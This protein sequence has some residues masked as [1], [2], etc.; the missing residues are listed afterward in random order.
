MRKKGR[1]FLNSLK[2][3]VEAQNFGDVFSTFFELGLPSFN[4]ESGE[5]F[6]IHRKR[7]HF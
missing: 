3:K 6:V 2:G 1:I 7:V 4:I 5:R